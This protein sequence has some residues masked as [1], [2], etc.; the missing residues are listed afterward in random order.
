MPHALTTKAISDEHIKAGLRPIVDFECIMEGWILNDAAKSKLSLVI[1]FCVM[2]Q[3]YGLTRPLT[4]VARE[5][6]K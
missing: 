6:C 3:P 1:T 2:L 4:Y 5:V